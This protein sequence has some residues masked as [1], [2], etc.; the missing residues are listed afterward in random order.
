MTI[1]LVTV[2]VR[3][4][5]RIRLLFSHALAS[6][7]FTPGLY[8]VTSVDG[9]AAD[10]PVVAAYAVLNSPAVVELHLG[11]D[12]VQGGHYRASAPGVPGTDGDTTPDPSAVGFRVGTARGGAEL[13]APRKAS[14]LERRLYGWDLV[15]DGNDFVETP[16]GDL[17]DAAGVTVARADL[18]RRVES[19][20]LPW[21]PSFGLHARAWVDAPAPALAQVPVLAVAEVRKDDRVLSA[22]A[23]IVF[24]AEGTPMVSVRPV[25]V[26]DRLVSSA[27]PIQGAIR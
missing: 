9:D 23:E 15:H 21:R 12:L 5:R 19:N 27:G 17:A 25:L 13:S 24:S 16:D 11:A 2:Q 20:G 8:T 10:P 4:E 26:G 7:A 3:H 22:E 14:A 6:G 18:R 1:A